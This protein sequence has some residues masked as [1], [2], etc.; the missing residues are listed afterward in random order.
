[1]PDID[2]ERW[3][4]LSPY[5]DEV[6]ALDDARRAEWLGLLA[7]RDP[8]LAAELEELLARDAAARREGFLSYRAPPPFATAGPSTA[9]SMKPAV[10]WR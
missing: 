1:M 9:S 4:V 3:R 8:G 5:L 6:L 7:G 10:S 2:A